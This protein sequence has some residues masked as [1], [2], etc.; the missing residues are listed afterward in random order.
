LQRVAK[1]IAALRPLRT[2]H[3]SFPSSGSSPFQVTSFVGDRFHLCSVACAVFERSFLT[4][5]ADLR[6]AFTSFLFTGF[7]GFLLVAIICLPSKFEVL[8]FCKRETDH[9][10]VSRLPPRG[11]VST[12]MI[13]ITAIHSLVA[14]SYSRLPTAPFAGSLPC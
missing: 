1:G 12:P 9:G 13:A 10:H 7:P 14:H 4:I 11:N 5:I 3:D 6:A 8:Q 2:G